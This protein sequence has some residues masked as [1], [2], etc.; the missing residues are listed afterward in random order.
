MAKRHHSRARV[1]GSAEGDPRKIRDPMTDLRRIFG[2]FVRPRET[3]ADVAAEPRWWPPIPVFLL[4]I[5]LVFW[6]VSFDHLRLKFGSVSVFIGTSAPHEPRVTPLFI[7]WAALSALSVA[8]GCYFL[9]AAAMRLT[10][11]TLGHRFSFQK[12]LAITS[13]AF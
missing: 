8:I 7:A 3:F 12:S 10:F 5:T 13:Y 4:T 9:A 1:P 6:H 2:V 11:R